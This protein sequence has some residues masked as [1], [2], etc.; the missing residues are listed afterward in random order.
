MSQ[1]ST[2]WTPRQRQIM[3]LLMRG[4]RT[5]EAAAHL[6]VSEHTVR[7]HLDRAMARHKARSRAQ[8]VNMFSEDTR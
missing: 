4:A 6:G 8:L 3:R 7:T 2:D 1:E 5:K